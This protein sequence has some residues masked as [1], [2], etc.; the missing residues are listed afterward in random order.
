MRPPVVHLLEGPRSLVALCGLTP[1]DL[2]PRKLLSVEDVPSGR[3]C[4]TCASVARA[5]KASA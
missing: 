1:G 2:T 3:V 5:K 4:K